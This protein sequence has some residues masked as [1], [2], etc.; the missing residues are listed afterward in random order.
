MF[1]GPCWKAFNTWFL[2]FPFFLSFLLFTSV[3]YVVRQLRAIQTICE[4]FSLFLNGI[5]ILFS[6]LKVLVA[7]SLGSFRL[8]E[9]IIIVRKFSQ[10]VQI[11]LILAYIIE[12]ATLI[13]I[14]IS[15]VNN[16]YCPYQIVLARYSLEKNEPKIWSIRLNQI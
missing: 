12:S 9:R 15:I 5:W 7:F 10:I 4:C 3:N 16:T 11:Y 2:R 8:K 1:S 6:F 13:E 14:N